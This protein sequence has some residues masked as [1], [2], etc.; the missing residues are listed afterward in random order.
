VRK[1]ADQ[2]HYVLT[3]RVTTVLMMGVALF[4]T[5]L[6]QTITQAWQ[7]L[8][9]FGAGV[10]LVFLLRWFWWRVNAWSEIFALVA[11]FLAYSYILLFTEIEFPYTLYYIVPFTTAVWL[12]GTFLTRPVENDHLK[13]F[14]RKVH[15][16]GVGW[17]QVAK[18]CPEVQAD[19]G[20]WALLCCW[21]ASAGMTYGVLFGVG[22]VILKETTSGLM[23]LCLAV[24]LAWIMYKILT[25]TGTGR[26]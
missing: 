7:F 20:Y 24:V 17:K 9:T 15:P 26:S 11:P 3:S 23:W 22:K 2:R 21:L 12:V 16:G 1:G 18:E 25:K 10:G 19:T 6:L 8:I 14:Y 4:I 13:A 5:T